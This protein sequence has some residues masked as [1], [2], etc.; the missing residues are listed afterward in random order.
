MNK[1][2]KKNKTNFSRKPNKKHS[3]KKIPNKKKSKQQIGGT[4][5][6]EGGFGCVV[7]PPLLSSALRTTL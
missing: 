7:T 4:L 1:K 3:N 2:T 5:L 6:G